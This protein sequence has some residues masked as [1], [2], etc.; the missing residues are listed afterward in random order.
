M[1]AAIDRTKVDTVLKLYV[2]ELKNI[3][4]KDFEGAVIYGSYARG[5]YSEESD[6]DIAV[7]T[8]RQTK[9]FYLLINSISEITFEYNVKY[10]VILSP[11]FQN[12]MDFNRMINVVPYYQNIQKEGVFIG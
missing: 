6:I 10:D 7:F 8:T 5:D 3:L 11:V 4:G 1:P 9:D 12:I 2:N